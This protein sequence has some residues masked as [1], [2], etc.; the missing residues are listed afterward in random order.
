MTTKSKRQ[1]QLRKLASM[2]EEFR[3]LLVTSLRKCID[4]SRD[5]FLTEAEAQR[6][7]DIY[8]KLVWPENKQLEQLAAEIDALHSELGISDENTLTQRF[9]YYCHLEG[10]NV[11]GGARA[12][13][14]VL[15]RNRAFDPG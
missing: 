1:K 5:L 4:G 7:D 9:R 14:T 3:N 11:P 15:A 13:P 6:R 10:P 8:P 2:E 12:G